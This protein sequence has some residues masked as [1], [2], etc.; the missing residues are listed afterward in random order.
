MFVGPVA[1]V[2]FVADGQVEH[3]E[4]V[5][6]GLAQHGLHEQAAR[7]EAGPGGVVGGQ[8]PVVAAGA[9]QAPVGGDRPLAEPERRDHGLDAALQSAPGR[10]PFVEREVAGPREQVN[11][12]GVAP[13]VRFLRGQRGHHGR[14][15]GCRHAQRGAHR[16]L[17]GQPAPL[18]PGVGEEPRRPGG[19]EVGEGGRQPGRVGLL[20]RAGAGQ[21]R[22]RVGDAGERGRHAPQP[23]QI[24]GRQHRAQRLPQP[25]RGRRI[26][27]GGEIRIDQRRAV[28]GQLAAEEGEHAQAAFAPPAQRC[29]QL[30]AAAGLAQ[31]G[32]AGPPAFARADRIEPGGEP[33]PRLEGV[34]GSAR[35]QVLPGG[36][37]GGQVGMD[38]PVGAL[39]HG[40]CGCS[41]CSISA[42]E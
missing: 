13:A 7:R 29:D 8:Y 16:A 2:G 37:R 11:A 4:P 6:D 22:E 39:G 23:H 24:H 28:V 42:L 21:Q 5:V 27:R 12:A 34:A 10:Q 32:H 31:L 14:Q 26:E 15:F 17:L 40:V 9:A 3:C 35:P 1:L 30:D 36:A 20:G 18:P 41:A 19:A 38:A 25:Q 33:V